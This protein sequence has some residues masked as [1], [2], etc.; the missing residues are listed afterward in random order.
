[1]DTAAQLESRDVEK[2]DNAPAFC[3]NDS[4]VHDDAAHSFTMGAPTALSTVPGADGS[5][6]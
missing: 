4:Y 1:M 3:S 2:R 6:L 5:N